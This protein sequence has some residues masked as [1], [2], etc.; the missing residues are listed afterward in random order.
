M[1]RFFTFIVTALYLTI[2]QASAAVW[3][4]AIDPGHGGKDPGAISRTMGMYEK[5]V[6]LSIASELKSFL[7]KDPNFRAVLTRRGDY[8]ISVPERSEIARKNKANY[9]ISIHADSSTN[10]ELK[11]AS[12][13]VLSNRRANDEMG[14]WLED[15]EKQSELLG[16]AGSVLSSNND[17][18]YLNQT[19]LDLQFGHSQRA[20][21]ELGNSILRNFS[22]I[23]DLS[24]S[25][26][27][28]ASL[29]VLRSPDIPSVLIETGYLSNIGEEAKLSSPSYRKRIAYII[30]QGLVDYRNRNTNSDTNTTFKPIPI[31]TD[32]SN[33]DSNNQKQAKENI[34]DSGIRHKV[35]SGETIAKIAQKY[36]V[37]SAD[38]VT[39]NKLK[40]QDLYIGESIKI[41]GLSQNLA[42]EETKQENN[43]KQEKSSDNNQINSDNTYIVKS[44][45]TL[46]SIANKY[47]AKES[48]LL[49]LNKL[50]NRNA[51]F[52]G[53]KLKIPAS[54]K[55]IENAEPEKPKD[56]VQNLQKDKVEKSTIRYQVKSGD[57]ISKL[58]EKFGIKSSEIIELNNLK[59]K[60]LLVGAIIKLPDNA[61]N[62]PSEDKPQTKNTTEIKQ[63]NSKNT[64]S[65]KGS[66]K[67]T[68]KTSEKTK[69]TDNNK[70]SVKAEKVNNNV[71][72]VS[73]TKVETNTNKAT[74]SDKVSNASKNKVDNATKTK[75]T[76]KKTESKAKV[77]VIE[78]QKATSTKT[79]MKKKTT[80]KNK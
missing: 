22:K 14:Q 24:R 53:K 62:V 5:N 75:V 45:D 20:G 65:E 18:K 16:G 46:Y 73:S 60:N 2:N 40:R 34:A 11:G 69:T 39:L 51:L 44:G 27:Q 4:I 12:V 70:K 54:A 30:Y 26:P 67:A 48:E 43:Q 31:S 23:T 1:K 3:T 80:N 56:I 32:N 7:D 57:N 13:W 55:P 29:G 41:P 35:A 38:I 61:K 6:T 58:A 74:H 8:Y 59:G 66:D 52:A 78:A 36:H 47:K 68:T 42:K 76:D 25:V 50:K 15:H 77:P 21:Y 19:V 9:L 79:V 49:E 10:P 33:S 64:K 72:S 63:N 28:H 71:Q 37:K 17:E